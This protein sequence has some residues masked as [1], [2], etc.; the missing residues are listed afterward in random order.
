M[1]LSLRPHVAA[2][3]EP[4]LRERGLLVRPIPYFE[5]LDRFR[6]QEWR[7]ASGCA[8]YLASLGATAARRVG[9]ACAFTEEL[10]REGLRR[11]YP[12]FPRTGEPAVRT[13]WAAAILLDQLLDEEQLSA[14]RLAPIHRWMSRMGHRVEGPGLPAAPAESNGLGALA[15][16]LADLL[17]DCRRRAVNVSAFQVFHGDLLN[18][19][20]AEARTPGLTLDATPDGLL[21]TA[22]RVKSAGLCWVGFRA[23]TLETAF[24]PEVERRCQQL[25]DALGEILWILDD[26]ADVGED[27]ARRVWSRTLWRLYDRAGGRLP[28]ESCTVDELAGL[29][30]ETDVVAEE[31]F[32]MADRVERL[33]SHA[34]GEDGRIIREFLSFWIMSW[35]GVYS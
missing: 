5:R 9:R 14:A 10:C 4:A 24:E 32:E 25:C 2:L 6:A 18:L 20:E 27:Y 22:V 34:G 13:L 8:P 3:A 1:A 17:E 21:R 28:D 26:L 12:P 33:E 23:A 29:L 30:A 19:F 7:L 15:A 31:V 35:L 16:M 11:L